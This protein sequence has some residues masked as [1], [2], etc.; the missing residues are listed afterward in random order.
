MKF[1]LKHFHSTQQVAIFIGILV[2]T[3]LLLFPPHIGNIIVQGADNVKSSIGHY[4]VFNPPTSSEICD[5]MSEIGIKVRGNKPNCD[6]YTYTSYIDSTRLH[7]QLLV[8]LGVFALIFI[9]L[10]RKKVS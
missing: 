5:R 8:C 10:Q 4:F 7:T 1:S 6:Y 3:T 2:L 9:A